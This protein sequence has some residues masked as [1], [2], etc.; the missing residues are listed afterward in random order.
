MSGGWQ[1]LGI[2]D[3][4]RNVTSIGYPQYLT[5]FSCVR[6]YQLAY[7]GNG[8]DYAWGRKGWLMQ[9]TAVARFQPSIASDQNPAPT[10]YICG[11][12]SSLYLTDKDFSPLDTFYIYLSMLVCMLPLNHL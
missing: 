2:Q 7:N 12:K 1:C 6:V 3:P 4:I 10:L 8:C 11:L 5:Q 9:N